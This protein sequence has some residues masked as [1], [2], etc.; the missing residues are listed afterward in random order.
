ME[1][2][3]QSYINILS[4]LENLGGTATLSE[5]ENE[6]QLSKV[7]LST[8]IKSLVD[9]LHEQN[10]PIDL[11]FKKSGVVY[12]NYYD[13][14]IKELVPHF[15]Q[16]SIM[17]KY[18]LT[19]LSPVF[20]S[21][22]QFC[23]SNNISQS[24]FYK[25]SSNLK[26]ILNEYKVS[27]SIKNN[28]FTGEEKHI[29]YFLF[30]FFWGTFF[31]FDWPYTI[32]KEECINVLNLVLKMNYFHLSNI[33]FERSLH[34]IAI[35]HQRIL[36][37]NFIDNQEEKQDI[38]LYPDKK[39]ATRQREQSFYA[40]YEQQYSLPPDILHNELVFL[41]K[42]IHSYVFDSIDIPHLEF[43]LDHPSTKKSL[44][45]QLTEFT[46]RKIYS[47]LG[48]D[49]DAIPQFKFHLFKI[50]N[51][52]L[53]FPSFS[54]VYDIEKLHERYQLEYPVA[55]SLIVK[56]IKELQHNFDLNIT[57]YHNSLFLEVHYVLL[58]CRYLDLHIFNKKISVY[59][60]C[61]EGKLVSQEIVTDL[62]Y[63]FGKKIEN[64]DIL[65]SETDLIITEGKLPNQE[66]YQVLYLTYPL[67]ILFFKRLENVI[68][69]NFSKK[70]KA[71]VKSLYKLFE[72]TDE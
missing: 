17:Y 1:K 53:E 3:F 42:L 23:L 9:I 71:Y 41:H 15:I 61:A 10:I 25:Q 32:L 66:S 49:F 43:I 68:N 64:H 27:L 22:H 37:N 2:K 18:L 28:C 11:I 35:T 20:I 19:L 21:A 52:F 14:Q 16:Q 50:H 56:I 8:D 54:V 7:T 6:L 48:T 60:S 63:R 57:K 26:N 51:H 33:E 72:K 45:F 36:S 29:R 5:L 62:L 70:N 13:L 40:I 38:L 31:N 24:H 47:Y 69:Q 12:K 65:Q 67:S 55:Y 4:C 39:H 46:I 34:L 58:L 59:V 30:N 44:P